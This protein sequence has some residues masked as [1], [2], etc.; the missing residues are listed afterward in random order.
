MEL[1]TRQESEDMIGKSL[2]FLP[3]PMKKS[4]TRDS[5]S[6]VDSDV[7]LS[8][9]RRGSKSE[10]ADLSDYDS[11]IKSVKEINIDQDSGADSVDDTLKELEQQ[12]LN[13]SLETPAV[14][15]V[16]DTITLNDELADKICTQV[17]F[18]FSD[19]NIIKDAFLL[20]HVKRNK[21]GYVSLKLISSFKRVKHFSRDWRVIREALT[22]SKKLEI[23]PQGTKLRRIDPLPPFDQTMPSRTILVAR[24]PIEKLTVESVAEIFKPYGEIALIRVLRPGYPAPS[25]VRQAISRRPELSANEEYAVIEFI[26]STSARIAMQMTLGDAKVFELRHSTDKKKKHQLTKKNT[27]NR[28][29]GEDNYNSSSCLSGSEPE[30]GRMRH[31]KS[32][33]RCPMYDIHTSYPLQVGSSDAWLSHKLSSCS[34]SSSEDNFMLRRLS[35]CSGSNSDTD[36]RYSTCSSGSEKSSFHPSYLNNIYRQENRHCSCCSSIGQIFNQ[37]SG[38]VSYMYKKK[39]AKRGNVSY[40]YIFK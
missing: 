18:Y 9:D 38:N 30:D 16:T 35:S 19:K 37:L 4:E 36:R 12:K 14:E 25:E 27:F 11:E 7:S 6:S 34:I 28:V 13:V 2:P 24:L 20:K 39:S 23:N 5:I 40:M 33:Q 26:D 29:A 3:P 15:K 1:E 10:E 8:F 17:E 32:I 21:E 31:K 22:R